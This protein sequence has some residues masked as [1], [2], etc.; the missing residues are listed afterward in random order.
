[1]CQANNNTNLNIV[2]PQSVSYFR[3]SCHSYL[4]CWLWYGIVCVILLFLKLNIVAD[5]IKLAAGGDQSW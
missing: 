4:D 5:V 1:M 2:L 3:Y